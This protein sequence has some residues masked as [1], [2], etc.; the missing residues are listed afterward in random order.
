MIGIISKWVCIYYACLCV[1]D[2]AIN[3]VGKSRKQEH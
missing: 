2:G 1:R 3:H